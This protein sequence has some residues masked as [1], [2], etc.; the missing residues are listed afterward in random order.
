MNLLDLPSEILQTLR[1]D[2]ELSPDHQLIDVPASWQSRSK[3]VLAKY[4]T[5]LVL[6]GL[7]ALW[8]YGSG[9]EPYV[10]SASFVN[11]R[12]KRNAT[13][14]MILWEERTFNLTDYV[15]DD[16]IGVTSRLRTICDVLR[17]STFTDQH[18]THVETLITFS[19]INFFTIHKSLSSKEKVPYKEL[20]LLRLDTLAFRH[21]ID[22]VDSINPANCI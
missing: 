18:K 4:G 12:R 22:V 17:F 14:P 10:H 9:P 13:I 21:A 16:G 3:S 11:G 5:D 1:L 19:G 20:A 2:G 15:L 7:S 8:A 6:T